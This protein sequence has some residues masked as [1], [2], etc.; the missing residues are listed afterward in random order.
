M[1]QTSQKPPASRLVADRALGLLGRATC[2]L[3]ARDRALDRE[4]LVDRIL[5]DRVERAAWKC[6]LIVCSPFAVAA[7]TSAT[8]RPHS[9]DTRSLDRS[10]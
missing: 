2:G 4:V 7:S 5:A 3:A 1:A 6:A 10:A 8:S 9:R